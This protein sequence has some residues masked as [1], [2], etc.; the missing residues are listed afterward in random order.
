MAI[1]IGLNFETFKMRNVI[2]FCIIT[3]LCV[4]AF[5][6]INHP[7]FVVDD[8]VVV[9]SCLFYF[10]EKK[11]DFFP[12]PGLRLSGLIVSDNNIS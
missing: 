9:I 11:P 7:S 5:I 3:I 1:G 8:D 2:K 4:F 10:F 12:H 6:G